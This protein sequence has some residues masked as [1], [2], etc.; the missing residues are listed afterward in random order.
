MSQKSCEDMLD[1]TSN[2]S[3]KEMAICFTSS[4]GTIPQLSGNSY[5]QKGPA[6]EVEIAGDS[7]PSV[8]EM[9]L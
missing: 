2:C 4:C 1:V 8:P 3:D 5:D 7:S 6:G 9:L